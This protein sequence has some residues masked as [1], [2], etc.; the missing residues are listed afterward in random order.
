MYEKIIS[1][2]RQSYDRK[3]EERDRK[4]IAPW[5]DRERK[6][7]LSLVL[8]EG[9]SRLLEVGAGTGLHGKFFQDQGL[10]V[11][12]VDLSPEM[13]KRCEEKGLEAYLMDFLHLDFPKSSFDAVFAMNCLLH[14]PKDN[15]PQ[16]LEEI[17]RILRGKGLF[18]WGQYG[19]VDKDGVYEGDHYE[20]KRYFS[21]IT[22]EWLMILAQELFDV[23]SF[24]TIELEEEEEF[25]FQSL[26]LRKD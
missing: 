25:H 8:D 4:E 21:F 18:Y 26:V 23:V 14:V 5:K 9:C 1:D 15:L 17:Y 24:K 20:P 3:V 6:H 19:G 2:L 10:Q 13:V 22:D 7:F 16:V 11:V 12:C